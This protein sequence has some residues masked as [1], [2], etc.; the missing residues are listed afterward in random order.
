MNDKAD[1]AFDCY[2][3]TKT[4]LKYFDSTSAYYNDYAIV[5]VPPGHEMSPFNKLRFPFSLTVW[6]LLLLNITI[7]IVVIILVTF[8]SKALRNFVFGERVTYPIL[9][10][11]AALLGITQY[12]LPQGTFARFLLMNFLVFTLN[13]RTL[14]QG[15]MFHLM[16][17]NLKYS[18]MQSV[19]EIIGKGFNFH[20]LKTTS[21]LFT[22]HSVLKSRLVDVYFY[23]L[24]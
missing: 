21:E 24:N 7:G 17:S 8:H 15:A 12:Q 4:R 22:N 3:L 13:M 23:F 5:I 16:Q 9:H 14:Y 6:S 10:M 20:V 19:D 11:F 18:E 2:W 1:L